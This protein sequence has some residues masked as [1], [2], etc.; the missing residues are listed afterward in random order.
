MTTIFGFFR[1]AEDDLETETEESTMAQPNG[2]HD[3]ASPTVSPSPTPAPLRVKGFSKKENTQNG[4][5][6]EEESHD[7]NTTDIAPSLETSDLEVSNRTIPQSFPQPKEIDG[8]TSITASSITTTVIK[9]KKKAAENETSFDETHEATMAKDTSGPGEPFNVSEV[10]RLPPKSPKSDGTNVASTQKG[11]EK[12]E[13]FSYSYQYASTAPPTKSKKSSKKAY[14]ANSTSPTSVEV[15]DENYSLS[16]RY[17]PTAAPT[18]G[19]K[20][21]LSLQPSGSHSQVVLPTSAGNITFTYY[22]DTTLAPLPVLSSQEKSSRYIGNETL[23][24]KN[25][26]NVTS[27]GNP[28][29]KYARSS[30]SP[31]AEDVS[32]SINPSNI[33]PII[34]LSSTSS[35]IDDENESASFTTPPILDTLA[36]MKRPQQKGSRDWK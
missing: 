4:L 24:Y 34:S 36:T 29:S 5:T 17:D 21:S 6:F 23:N 30:I 27:E 14:D 16:Y 15:T 35:R 12:D 25:H 31:N 18:K 11:A 2:L 20:L 10:S 9:N 26:D 3:K 1:S 7:A 8:H 28:E 33:D 32:T 19:K 13:Y 22:E